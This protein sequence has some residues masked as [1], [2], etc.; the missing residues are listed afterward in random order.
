MKTKITLLF[1]IFVNFISV[2]GQP[3]PPAG[4]AL[5]F[6]GS[7][8][9][10]TINTPTLIPIENSNYTVEAWVYANT[11]GN[12]G[13]IGWGDY[14]TN[15]SVNA[16]HLDATGE[17]INY[18][19][20]NDLVIS[21]GDISGDWHH[22]ATTWDGTTRKIYLDGNLI[23]SDN[24]SAVPTIPN[25]DNLTIGIT[26]G[27]EYFDGVI[28][29]VRIW[30][31]VRSECHISAA[32]NHELIGN[33]YGLVAYYNFNQGYA[34]DNNST[35]TTL[36]DITVNG[37]NG[38]LNNFAL[39]G[40]TSNW[41]YSNSAISGIYSD[42]TIPVP[43]VTNLPD[44]TGECSASVSIIPTATDACDGSIIGTTSDD[45]T[46]TEQGTYVITW[47]YDDKNGNI[48]TQT[49]NVIVDDNTNPTLTCVGNQ[50]VLASAS[51]TYT[52]LNTEFDLTAFDD[53]CGVDSVYNSY[54]M[55]SSLDG[56]VL[57]EGT[58]TITWYVVDVNSN[59]NSC[60]FDVTVDVY[61]NVYNTSNDINL[62]IYPNP[63]SGV[64]TLNANFNLSIDFT[65]EIINIDGKVMNSKKYN[66]V[67]II[68]E[69]IN[70]N[71]LTKGVYYI[72]VFNDSFVKQ[73]KIII[74]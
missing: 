4:E 74:Y 44:I 40:T 36:N 73:E 10:I 2:Q 72:R 41:V 32:M 13:I 1:I 67:N 3:P 64:F 59:I 29:E 17:I 34:E 48:V 20:S 54:N 65:V 39:I 53:N 30:N 11:M 47:T 28:D 5:N 50:I 69:Q 14:G 51:H 57:P 12:Y 16:I 8:N 37:N 15:N 45:L 58:T 52:V 63:N 19:G 31:I 61:T 71:C 42:A 66:N 35:E 25:A 26:N 22:I 6:D 24:P 49:Q 70:V 68:N 27:S 56:E 43:D 38:T 7:N 23:G 18:W 60:S 62:S 33:E 55:L 46:Y 21:T 9:Y